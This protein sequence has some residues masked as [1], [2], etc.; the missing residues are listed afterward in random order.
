[1]GFA[2]LVRYAAGCGG[3]R[4]RNA[5]GI[6]KERNAQGGIVREEFEQKKCYL[7]E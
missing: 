2:L 6:L 1:M 4:E 7:N 5:L 3:K